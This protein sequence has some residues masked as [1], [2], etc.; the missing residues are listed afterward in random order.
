MTEQQEEKFVEWLLETYADYE[1]ED[2]LVIDNGGAVMPLDDFINDY[3]HDE[4]YI[5]EFLDEQ[6]E[7]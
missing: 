5:K 1:T 3:I 7:D 2:G 4:I 6:K